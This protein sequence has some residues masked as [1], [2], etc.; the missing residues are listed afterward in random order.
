MRK[1][2]VGLYVGLLST[3]FA[4][5]MGNTTAVQ[6]K[7]VVIGL[8]LG[9][10]W[11]Q[12]GL[13][14]TVQLQPGLANSYVASHPTLTLFSG[15]L[16][17]GLQHPLPSHLFGQLGIAAALTDEARLSGVVWETADP[18]FNN[19]TY[20]YKIKHQRVTLKTALL[21]KIYTSWF[22][23][24][25]ASVGVGFN[26]ASRFSYTPLLFEAI[27]PPPFSS[28]HT[29]AFTYTLGAGVQKSLDAHWRLGL[30]YEC[31]DWGP[32][33]L[34]LV[35]SQ[36]PNNQLKLGHLYTHELLFAVNYLL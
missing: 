12:V 16:F 10:A 18:Q 30:G 15:E 22:P 27:P 4:G 11:Y 21:K 31:A 9:P 26:Y 14:Q 1:S 24:L 13:T 23:Y 17:F 2:T 5:S 33:S 36:T 32:S 20:N 19:F 29:T 6:T 28:K 8:S 7:N 35:P 3:A 25:S 34:G